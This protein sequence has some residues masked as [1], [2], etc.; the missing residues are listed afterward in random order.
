[1]KILAI[2]CSA[3]AA[4]CAVLEDERLLAESFINVKLT[5]S[6]TMLPMVENMLKAVKIPLSEIDGFAVTNGPGSFT[7]I[8]IGISVVK[9]LAFAEKKPCV[10]V[11]SLEALANNILGCNAIVCAAMDARC[12]QFYNGIFLNDGCAISRLCEDNACS[13]EE[14]EQKLEEIVSS[15]DYSSYPVIM[16][17]DGADI[18]V[19]NQKKAKFSVASEHLKYARASSAARVAVKRFLADE[20]CLPENLSPIYLRLPQAERQL[21]RTLKMN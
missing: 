3:V 20:T 12:N 13:G 21:G 1:M 5:H 14:L 17:G 2:D 19:K 9:G 7:G 11:S 18:F 16:V 6:Q 4:S 15:R 10:G 8:R